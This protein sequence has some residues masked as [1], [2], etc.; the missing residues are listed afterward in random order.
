MTD[1][2]LGGGQA[3]RATREEF[4]TFAH[5]ADIL[6][7]DA[8]YFDEDIESRRGWGHSFVTEACDLAVDSEVGQLILFHHDPDRTDHQIDAILESARS[9][10]A[11]KNSPV[12]CNAAHEGMELDL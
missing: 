6:I 7:H 12:K 8:Q 5:R 10:I 2:E 11:D 1:N 9:Y 3:E 4:A